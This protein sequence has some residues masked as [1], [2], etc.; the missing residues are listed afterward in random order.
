MDIFGL[1]VSFYSIFINIF[2]ITDNTKKL[3]F[4]SIIRQIIRVLIILFMVR[5]SIMSLMYG[6]VGIS[7]ISAFIYSY[8]G[9]KLINYSLWEILTDLIPT[10]LIASI[11]AFLVFIIG[12]IMSG[13]NQYFIFMI[14]LIIM[15]TIVCLL[16]FIIKEKS[17]IELKN[18]IFDSLK[19]IYNNY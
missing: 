17:F 1:L 5:I 16:S 15:I 7:I 19:K 10:I 12:Y 8:F 3:L 4:I 11:A 6:I 13:I 18:I 2:L 9:G 14:Q